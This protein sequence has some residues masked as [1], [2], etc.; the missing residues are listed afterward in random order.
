MKKLV[1]QHNEAGGASCFKPYC[2]NGIA[3]MY[4]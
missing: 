2:K 3:A 1:S 4:L